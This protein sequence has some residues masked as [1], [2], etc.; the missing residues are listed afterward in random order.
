MYSLWEEEL[1][2][3]LCAYWCDE[4]WWWWRQTICANYQYTLFFS[5]VSVTNVWKDFCPP[6]VT[7]EKLYN[8]GTLQPNKSKVN[9]PWIILADEKSSKQSQN[10]RTRIKTSITGKECAKFPLDLLPFNIRQRQMNLKRPR[11]TIGLR[12]KAIANLFSLKLKSA[13]HFSG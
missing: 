4:N 2:K 11:S 12:T 9:T 13:F 7:R 10:K 1:E 3:A 6:I 5:T 8:R